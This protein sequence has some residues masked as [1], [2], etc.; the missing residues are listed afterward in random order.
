MF[1]LVVSTNCDFEDT[2]ND[3]G[4]WRRM[5][6][7]PFEAKFLENPYN[8][9]KYPRSECPYQFPKDKTLE[10]KLLLWAPDFISILVD[11][12]YQ[13]MGIVNDCKIVMAHS[14]SHREKQ[15]Y[16]AAYIRQNI[17]KKEGSCIKKTGLVEDF[18]IWYELNINKTVP[19]NKEIIEYMNNRFGIYSKVHHWR[20]IEMI[21]DEVVEDEM[22]AM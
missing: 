8:D 5:R 7:I 3:D 19:P 21:K 16:L 2:S 4:T 15:D 1:K 22:D 12:A 17:R 20:N 18:K 6:Y 9:D 10:D 13:N 11:K 14:D